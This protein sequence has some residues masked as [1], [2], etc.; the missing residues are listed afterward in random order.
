MVILHIYPTAVWG[1][2]IYNKKN[3]GG[4]RGVSQG[5]AFGGMGH[6]IVREGRAIVG[7]GPGF[8]TGWFE[9]CVS[10]WERYPTESIVC[11]MSVMLSPRDS[12]V[13]ANAVVSTLWEKH[14][15]SYLVLLL[16]AGPKDY[17]LG[18]SAYRS[19]PRTAYRL[20]HPVA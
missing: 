17:S 15:L 4:C 6:T 2:Y 7:L 11:R 10:V 13:H 3:I 5:G 9:L 18:D 14:S 12:M 8:G 16:G 1:E 19:G 20:R